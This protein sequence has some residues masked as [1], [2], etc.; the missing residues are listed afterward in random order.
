MVENGRMKCAK[1]NKAHMCC[2]HSG[3]GA[4]VHGITMVFT[5]LGNAV[6]VQSAVVL[7][8]LSFA[9]SRLV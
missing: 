3:V 5:Y 1:I 7:Q 6:N 9:I 2:L 4:L 8:Y